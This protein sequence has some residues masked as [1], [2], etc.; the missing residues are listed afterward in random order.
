MIPV[1]FPTITFDQR[2]FR[3][4]GA[5]QAAAEL[6]DLKLRDFK[7]PLESA[8][9]L[10]I[11]PSIQENFNVGGRPPWKRLA[12]SYVLYRKP[13]PILIQTHALERAT[14]AKSNW[15][16][17]SD[18]LEMTGLSEAYYGRF[19]Q[20]GTRRMPAR[21]FVLY[22]PEDVEHIV[23]IF[24]IWVDGLIDTYWTT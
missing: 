18:S 24:E 9:D 17:T 4:I 11:L 12:T 22:Q 8:L 10:V 14:Q 5:I 23:Q 2:F 20:A 16:V 15:N 21:P 19:H 13:G 1:G 6:L 3:D 7:E